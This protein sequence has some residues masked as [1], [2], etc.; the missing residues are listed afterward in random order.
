[1]NTLP[2]SNQTQDMLDAEERELAKIV[3][4]LP[5]GEPPAALDALILKAASDAVS[6]QSS[7]TKSRFAK[8]LLSS[9]V[10]WLG[11]AAASVLTVGVG[12]QVYQSIRAP[13]NEIG[14]YEPADVAM[15]KSSDDSASDSM[16]IEMQAPREPAPTSPPPLESAMNAEMEAKQE[17]PRARAPVAN[18]SATAQGAL[19]DSTSKDKA[20]SPADD[21]IAPV[22]Q[23]GA[24]DA[25]AEAAMPAVAAPAPSAPVVATRQAVPKKEDAYA[26][27]G[28]NEVA[29]TGS[30]IQRADTETASPVAKQRREQLGRAGAEADSEAL[31]K[32]EVTGSRIKHDDRDLDR[33]LIISP[34]EIEREIANEVAED[35]KLTPRDW[36]VSIRSR[37]DI[38]NLIVAKRSLKKF[39][40]TYPQLRIPNDL[41]PLLR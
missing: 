30:R 13:I 23:P 16:V 7:S 33:A 5:G 39:H 37:R 40:E 19:A 11:T 31:E 38:G 35:A 6:S 27:N 34:K 8:G 20:A 25:A 10:M 21:W 24:A 2:P 3:R 9:S 15:K 18:A 12:W 17:L 22:S 32:V 36:L 41:K 28:L 1:M 4:A 29:V 14:I 26:N